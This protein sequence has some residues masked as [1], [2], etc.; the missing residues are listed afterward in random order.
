[1][2]AAGS[3]SAKL[4]QYIVR[5]PDG[6]REEIK[7]RARKAGRSMNAEI[8]QILSAALNYENHGEDGMARGDAELRIRIPY[9]VRDRMKSKAD[10]KNRTMNAE[11]VVALQSHLDAKDWAKTD[12]RDRFAEAALVGLPHLCA[13]DTLLDGI[14]FEQHVARNAYKIADAMMTE[15]EREA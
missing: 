13:Q 6:M 10:Q 8:V 15:R 12:L 14:T 1:M 3:P 7:E 4:E 5:F 9:D 2:S 11:I